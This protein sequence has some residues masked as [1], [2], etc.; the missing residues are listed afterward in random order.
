MRWRN[1][2]LDFNFIAVAV[3]LLGIGLIT[4]Y[5]LSSAAPVNFFGRQLVFG[6]IGAALFVFALN[7][8][9]NDWRRWAPYIFWAVTALLILTAIIG[10]ERNA[11]Q[12]WLSIGGLFSAQPAEFLKVAVLLCA[13]RWAA[14]VFRERNRS[15]HLGVGEVLRLAIF[16]A[17]PLVFVSA[18][19]DF[20]TVC[21][22]IVVVL[23]IVFLAGLRLRWILLGALLTGVWA[24]FMIVSSPYRM[25]RLTAFLDPFANL[26]TTGYNQVHALMAFTN[27]GWWGVG[28]GRSVEKFG[29]LP[30]AENDFIIAIIAEELGLVGFGLVCALYCF[31]VM[32]AFSIGHHAGE[33]REFFGKFYADGVAVILAMQV[34]INIGGSVA[35]LPSKGF[36]LPLVSYG[37][38]SL[39][40]TLWMFV[41]LMRVDLEN[42]RAKSGAAEA[43]RR[44]DE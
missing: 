8:S 34:F 15:R 10:T 33:R 14:N 20:G 28:W 36:T 27:G 29:N 1:L 19:P 7:I 23:S 2:T 9:L 5:S 16:C 25:G 4:L 6:V 31:L 22:I 12:R 40:V 24:Y 37:G 39:W 44:Y 43:E 21:L 41:I 38:S 32:R 17:I 26:Y 3:A 35:L 30:E 13:A 11:A 18:Q 42:Q